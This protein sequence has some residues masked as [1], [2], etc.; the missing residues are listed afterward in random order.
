MYTR[1][2]QIVRLDA[3]DRDPVTPDDTRRRPRPWLTPPPPSPIPSPDRPMEQNPGER[4]PF[5]LGL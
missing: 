1:I 2:R 5:S 4:R 3:L